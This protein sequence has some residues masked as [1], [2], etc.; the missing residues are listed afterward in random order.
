MP[1][2]TKIVATLAPLER[3][4]DA[5]AHVPRGRGTSCA[6]NFSHGAPG[7]TSAVPNWVREA[8]RKTPERTVAS[9]AT[10]RARRS[11]IGKFKTQGH[12]ES[13]RHAFV[14]VCRLRDWRPGRVV[15]TTRSC[16]AT[17]IPATLCC[18]LTTARSCSMWKRSWARGAQPV[19]HGGC[20]PTQSINRLG[21]ALPPP[22]LSPGL[23]DIRHG[24]KIKVTTSP[25]PSPVERRHGH[26][27]AAFAHR[28]RRRSSSPD[29]ARGAVEPKALTD[30]CR[31]AKASWSRAV[32]SPLESA[33][34]RFGRAKAHD[35]PCSRQNKLTITARR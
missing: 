35:S 18:F 5:G 4:P 31:P 21:A 14:L 17:C 34:P 27:K 30:S 22:A 19:R 16:R 1:R 25:F 24:A 32:I 9:W 12:S 11:G 7:P 6:L 3:S 15:L 33:T 26:G 23:D 13:R 20:S 29:R 8:C 2:S 28:R 10:C